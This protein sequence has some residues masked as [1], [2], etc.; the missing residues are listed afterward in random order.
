MKEVLWDF[1]FIIIIVVVAIVYAIFNWQKVKVMAYN[2]MLRAKSLA[3][4]AILTSGKEQEDW[5]VDTVYPLLPVSVRLFIPKTAFRTL[6][7]KLYLIGK[8]WIDD[9]KFNGSSGGV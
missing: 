1:R 6:V 5:V 8:D 2:G 9:G 4:D 7:R 3:K